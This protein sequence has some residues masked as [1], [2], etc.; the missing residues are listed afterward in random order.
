VKARRESGQAAVLAVVMI[1]ALLG[2]AALV[3]DAGSWF[4][5]RRQV[6]SVADAAALAGA[7]SWPF[8]TAAAR[9]L[10]LQYA[11]SNGGGVSSGDITFETNTRA[12]DTIVVHASQ[13]A[14]GFF[15][16]LFGIDTV[17]VGATAKA[18]AATPGK[19]FGVAPIGVDK[20]HPDLSGSGCPC[21]GHATTLDLE[22]TGPGAF[23]IL[24]LDGSKGGT[25]PGTL[26]DWIEN[27]F[28]G[29][30]GLGWYG[31]DPGAKFDS[32]QVHD[33]L[34]GREGTELLF[35]VYDSVQGQG[36][37]FQYNVVGWAGFHLTGFDARGSSGLLY[38][39][40]THVVW[41]GIQDDGEN[42]PDLGAYTISLVQ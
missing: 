3:V 14:G 23:R 28:N 10:A 29:Y 34:D 11:G 31:S 36:A 30:L 16:R 25:G 13:V 4:R 8:D 33:G 19:A 22:K 41:K 42:E 5:A 32:S 37:N 15:S 20:S 9:S 40:F 26:G 17:T 6:Q 21:W 24:N 35:P 2:M 1:T 39:W 12:N 7:Q 27:G 18:R 38:G